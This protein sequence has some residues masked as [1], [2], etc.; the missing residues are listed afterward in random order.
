MATKTY[1][2]TYQVDLEDS[3]EFPQT[4]ATFWLHKV[5]RN[6]DLNLPDFVYSVTTVPKVEELKP[7]PTKKT[8]E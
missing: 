1:T 2:L 4:V 8:G 5:I 7:K 3:V 6:P